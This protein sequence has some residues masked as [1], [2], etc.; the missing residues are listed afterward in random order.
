MNNSSNSIL[1][2]QSL[3]DNLMLPFKDY[4]FTV[5][6]DDEPSQ[7]DF[8]TPMDMQG[9]NTCAKIAATILITSLLLVF[10]AMSAIGGFW[11]S[12]AIFGM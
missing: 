9:A 6:V 10:I 2:N 3:D 8:D 12:A 7:E 11:L 1:Y 4:G 5:P